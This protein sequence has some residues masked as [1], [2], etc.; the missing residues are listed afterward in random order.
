MLQNV[1]LILS[2]F[3]TWAAY[4]TGQVGHADLPTPGERLRGAVLQEF[5]KKNLLE[6]YR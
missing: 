2:Y 5:R 1:F 3:R 4:G 6:Q